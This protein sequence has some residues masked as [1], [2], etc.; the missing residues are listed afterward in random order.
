VF[1]P[2]TRRGRITRQPRQPL[3]LTRPARYR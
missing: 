1:C 3:G 2:R